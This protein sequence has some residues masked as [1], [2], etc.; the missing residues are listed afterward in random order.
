MNYFLKII[1]LTPLEKQRRVKALDSW[2]K[3]LLHLR[4][5]EENSAS[6]MF[7]GYCALMDIANYCKN[8]LVKEVNGLIQRWSDERPQVRTLAHLGREAKVSDSALRRL[9]NQNAKIA[10]DMLFRIVSV[11]YESS[12]FTELKQK[13]NTLPNTSKW[14]L[15]NYSFMESVSPMQEYKYTE[16]SDEVVVSPIGFSIFGLVSSIDN[17][18]KDY[19][20]DQFGLRGIAEAELL[21]EKGI[22]HLNQNVYTLGT[23]HNKVKFSKKAVIS[24]MPEITRLYLKADSDLNAAIF[25]VNGVSEEGYSKLSMAFQNLI[26]VS[27]QIINQHQGNI[28]VVMSGFIDTMT[29]QAIKMELKNENAH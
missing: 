6:C 19:I 4:F 15:R 2:E 14:L 9:K 28:P 7:F 29:T 25:E 13:T 17:V 12:E 8:E 16:L 24:L 1:H 20:K 21:V 10:D 3:N 22:L 18:G 23:H 5:G 26:N 27:A 11:I